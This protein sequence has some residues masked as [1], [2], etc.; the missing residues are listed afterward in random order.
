MNTFLFNT[1]DFAQSWSAE[2]LLEYIHPEM[3]VLVIPLMANDGWIADILAFNDEYSANEQYSETFSRLGIPEN[4]IQVADIYELSRDVLVRRIRECDVVCLVSDNTEYAI[5]MLEDFGLIEILH[6]YE[7]ILIG[8]GECVKILS[9]TY[10]SDTDRELHYGVSRY[11]DVYV[12]PGFER[13]L[14]DYEHI[15]RYL[16]EKG[17]QVIILDIHGGVCITDQQIEV[18]GDAF[19][20]SEKDLDTLYQLYEEEY[21][22]I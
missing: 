17:D 21:L 20:A 19:I 4:H 3:H 2:T 9:H 7:G 22:G 18:L 12:Y 1:M 13:S 6:W 15:I 11:H 8:V 5:N 10:E 16:E 14:R